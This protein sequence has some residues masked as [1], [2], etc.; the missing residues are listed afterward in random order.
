M[1]TTEAYWTNRYVNQQ[2]G[3]D[4]GHV[5]PPIKEYFDQVKDKDLR[6]LIPGA[7]NSYEAEYLFQKGFHN[8]HIIDIAQPPLANFQARVPNFPKEQII[9][10]D[11]FQHRGTYDI[12]VEQTFFCAID[13]DPTTRQAYASQVAALL[14]PGGKLV[15]LWFKHPLTE[16]AS[17]PFGGS[18]AEYLGYFQEQFEMRYFEDCHNSIKPRLGNEY[19]GLFL[20]K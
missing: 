6:I 7:G 9:H 4:M 2:T 11:F 17:R 10:D 13:Y 1:N 3:W 8:T 16:N 12:L 5:S 18:K 20:R 14:K 15:G 19:F